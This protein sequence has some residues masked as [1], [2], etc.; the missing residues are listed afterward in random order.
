MEDIGN[1]V[2][3]NAVLVTRQESASRHISSD[4][5]LDVYSCI[6]NLILDV[7]YTSVNV[8]VRRE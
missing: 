5:L 4:G 3:P 6:K 8:F 7:I 1:T 2:V